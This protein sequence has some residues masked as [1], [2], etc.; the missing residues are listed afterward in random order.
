MT[1][2]PDTGK[3]G[4]TK[5]GNGENRGWL[6]AIVGS[7]AQIWRGQERIVCQSYLAFARVWEH[8]INGF[9]GHSIVGR[10]VW[11]NWPT[12]MNF[13]IKLLSSQSEEFGEARNELNTSV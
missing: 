1:S 12:S 11:C 8:L 3:G 10:F 4:F 9:K 6:C 5:S 13:T 2:L 7:A